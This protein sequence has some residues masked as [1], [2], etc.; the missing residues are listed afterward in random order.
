MDQDACKKKKNK[1]IGDNAIAMVDLGTKATETVLYRDNT[2]CSKVCKDP[3][4]SDCTS[5]IDGQFK[6]VREL[7]KNNVLSL[8]WIPTKLMIAACLTCLTKQ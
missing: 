3:R 2:S 4:S 7:V 6:K 1:Q 8:E 5:H